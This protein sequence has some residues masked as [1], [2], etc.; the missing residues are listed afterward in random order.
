[1][2][3]SLLLEPRPLLLSISQLVFFGWAA[4]ISLLIGGFWLLT[5]VADGLGNLDE[6]SVQPRWRTSFLLA[7]LGVCAYFIIDFFL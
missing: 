1:M 2:V 7:F 3:L 6:Q 4:F 5:R